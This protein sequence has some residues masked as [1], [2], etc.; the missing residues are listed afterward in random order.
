MTTETTT[1]P[2]A[3]VYDQ[4][5]IQPEP[6]EIQ[7]QLM[8]EL[9]HHLSRHTQLCMVVVDPDNRTGWP[10]KVGA[11]AALRLLQWG[12]SLSQPGQPEAVVEVCT[13]PPN[14]LDLLVFVTGR[15]ESGSEFTVWGDVK[16]TSH[17]VGLPDLADPNRKVTLT[18]A[19]LERLETGRYAGRLVDVDPTLTDVAPLTPEPDTDS[20]PDEAVDEVSGAA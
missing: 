13:V 14:P 10:V 2:R 19:D 4:P 17:L 7:A 6:A 11:G 5:Q 8:H 16:N 3:T 20:A 15:L 1:D 12:V 9:A 18:L